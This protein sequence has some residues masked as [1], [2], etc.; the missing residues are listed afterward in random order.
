MTK[1]TTDSKT[2]ETGTKV[3]LR[4]LETRSD[5]KGGVARLSQAAQTRETG[6]TSGGIFEVIVTLRDDDG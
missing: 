1:H 6:Y 5:P 4:D 2:H 3:R